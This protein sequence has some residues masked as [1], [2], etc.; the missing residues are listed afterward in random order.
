MKTS[1][2][3]SAKLNTGLAHD[4]SAQL[5]IQRLTE[6]QSMAEADKN[7]KFHKDERTGNKFLGV[8]MKTIFDTA[9]A[10]T[11]MP[12]KEVAKLLKSPYYEMRM[13]AVSI[14]DFKARAKATT[15]ESKEALFKLYIDNH[16]RIDTWDMVDRSAPYVVGGYLHDKSRKIL[17]TLAKSKSMCER[18]TSIVST[19][20]FI[21]QN[22][23]DETFKIA[24]I[25]VNDK[26][27]LIQKAVGSWI[28]EAGKR[29]KKQL[30]EFLD[31]YASIMPRTML[32]YAIEKLSASQKNFYM[33]KEF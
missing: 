12:I 19:Y 7:K 33:K 21:R 6:N 15:D 14:M 27:D 31:N 20:Y 17:Y 30:L 18:R 8:R 16:D 26:H 11:E 24:A 32:R 23:V 10:F 28:R 22:D 3:N 4:L 25:L 1:S 13:G 29:D 2:K 9:K 5:F